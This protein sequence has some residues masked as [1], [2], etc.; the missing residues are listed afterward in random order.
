MFPGFLLFAGRNDP[1]VSNGRGLRPAD[2]NYG[3]TGGGWG[4]SGKLQEYLARRG[5]VNVIMSFSLIPSSLLSI[6]DVKMKRWRSYLSTKWKVI[7]II[8]IFILIN[9]GQI[10]WQCILHKLIS[11]HWILLMLFW[12]DAF[13]DRIKVLFPH[14]KVQELSCTVNV[15]S[16]DTPLPW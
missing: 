15:K 6:I 11:G 1:R 2:S 10:Q 16:L 5:H 13:F 14:W 3:Q 12:R 9:T 8:D 4:Q 7:F